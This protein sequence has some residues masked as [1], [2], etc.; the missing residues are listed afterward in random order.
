MTAFQVY[1]ISTKAGG[2]GPLA[3]P[4]FIAC[5]LLIYP[6]ILGINLTKATTVIMCDSDWNPQNDLQAIARA[7]RIGQTKT[8]KVLTFRYIAAYI[9]LIPLGWFQVYRL[10]CQGSVE[11]QMLDRI[12]RKLFLSMKIMGS[13]DGSSSSEAMNLGLTALMNILRKGSS[14]LAAS[15]I[16]MSLAR[17]LDADIS[18]IL[19][20]SRSLEKSREA[21]IKQ[22]LRVEEV[23][24]GNEKLLLDAEEEERRLL[25]GVA[26]VQSRLFEGKMV[27]HQ[28]SNSEI[29]NEW[30]DLSKRARVDRTVVVDG[31]TFIMTPP[32]P[33]TVLCLYSLSCVSDAHTRI[34]GPES[35]KSCH[36][37]AQKVRVG[38]LVHPLS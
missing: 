7:H 18:D 31:M 6:S 19:E 2:L 11:D 32:A 27:Q 3:P 34:L 24:G 14:A 29:A 35:T 12:R 23:D 37:A 20:D 25:S 26:Q 1:L 38:R 9:T 22:E 5:S 33:T 13:S 16:G 17:F 4:F 36:Q 15:G 21:K 10:I 28:Q 30:R 8:V